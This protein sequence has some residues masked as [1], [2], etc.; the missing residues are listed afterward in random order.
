MRKLTL[1]VTPKY[2]E[3]PAYFPSKA[4]HLRRIY[5]GDLKGLCLV[6][7]YQFHHAVLDRDAF[8]RYEDSL[9]DFGRVV[10]EYADNVDFQGFRPTL[11]ALGIDVYPGK[12]PESSWR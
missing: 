1:A 4:S 10:I 7:S 3:D 12:A 11:E 2:Y 8:L 5:N 6:V 9:Q